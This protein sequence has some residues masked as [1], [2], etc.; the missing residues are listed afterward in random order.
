MFLQ[1]L[2]LCALV[3]LA[4]VSADVLSNFPE[5]PS[6]GAQIEQEPVDDLLAS[7]SAAAPPHGPL[8]L[9]PGTIVK[10]LVGGIDGGGGGDS[11][12]GGSQKQ[13][14]NPDLLKSIRT[15]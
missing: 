7:G 3:L 1:K 12:G 6:L 14:V 11:D 5:G 8:S 4:A 10:T 15:I 2:F 9:P 13:S